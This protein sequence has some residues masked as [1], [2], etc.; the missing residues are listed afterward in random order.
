MGRGGRKQALG[1]VLGL[2]VAVGATLPVC[3]AQEPLRVGV[4]HSLSGTMAASETPV[5]EATRF[6][7]HELNAAGGV[8]GRTVEVRFV[9][10]RSDPAHSAGEAERLITAEKVRVL[11][12]CWTSA[13]RKALKP[14]VERHD[15]LLFYPLQ[16][17]GLESSENIVYVGSAPNQQITPA[18]VWAVRTFG[19]RLY[20][21]GSDYVFPRVAHGII[22]EMARLIGAEVVGESLIPLGSGEVQTGVDAIRALAPDVVLNTINGDSNLAF[23]QAWKGDGQAGKDIPILSFSLS[24]VETRARPDLM[25][26]SYTAWSYFQGVESRENKDFLERFRA[27]DA[28]TGQP[29]SRVVGDPMEA[30]YVGVNLW[31]QAV[32]DAQS[33]EPHRVRQVLGRQSF[34]APQGIVS[35]DPETRHVWRTSRIGR[36]QEDGSMRVEWAQER[37]VRPVPFPTFRSRSFWQVLLQ[38]IEGEAP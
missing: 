12:G 30:A 29:R 31:A 35:V 13:C 15:H 33:A 26:G 23:F 18:L 21:I 20:L 4:I 17:E 7:V 2:G 14:V 3:H 28:A 36:V 1:V 27:Y 5:M 11:F 19:P 38:R 37:P 34:A 10:G 8:L 16:Y 24:E 32:R 25:A 9:D 22:R 6:A